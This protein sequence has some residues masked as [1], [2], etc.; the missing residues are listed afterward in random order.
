M[1]PL[2]ASVI[3]TIV[4]AA[5]GQVAAWAALLNVPLTPAAE[6]NLT[7]F[8]GFAFTAIYYL[9]VRV[10]EQQ[11]PA[12]G[13][14]LGLPKSPDTYS[15]SVDTPA[16]PAA[17]VTNVYAPAPSADTVDAPASFAPT[18]AKIDA[19]PAEVSAPE[20]SAPEVTPAATPAQ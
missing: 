13:I 9:I 12:F 6:V 1:N 10:V 8:L 17:P 15:K 14:L 7:A 4:P 18:Q 16:G 3:R 2:V 5:V 11:W 19:L 20:V